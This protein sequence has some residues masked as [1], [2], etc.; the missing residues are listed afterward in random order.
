MSLPRRHGLLLLGPVAVVIV[1]LGSCGGDSS[2]RAA[3]SRALAESAAVY[4]EITNQ[5]RKVGETRQSP[6]AGVGPLR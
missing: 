3:E 4:E 2:R 6:G 1:G 5:F